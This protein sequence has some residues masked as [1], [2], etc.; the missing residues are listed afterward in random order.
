MADRSA[1]NNTI[2]GIYIDFLG[3]N[4]YYDVSSSFV[5]TDDPLDS[6]MRSTVKEA[7]PPEIYSDLE[8][9]VSNTGCLCEEQ[10]FIMGYTCAV[11]YLYGSVLVAKEYQK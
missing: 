11:K 7:L 6:L 10:G 8:D 9:K 3:S 2:R 1:A 5:E 4:L